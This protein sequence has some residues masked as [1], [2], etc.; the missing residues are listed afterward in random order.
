MNFDFKKQG[1]HLLALII[2]L[3]TAM[4]Y[5]IPQFQGKK[6][7]QSDIIQYRGMAQEIK[8]H[9]DQYGETTLWT[10]QHCNDRRGR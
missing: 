4:V 5:F 7:N 3:G 10:P 9:K 6:I 1:I 8:N 2:F